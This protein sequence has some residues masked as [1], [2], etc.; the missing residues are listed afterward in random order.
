MVGA[1]ARGD[2]PASEWRKLVA[3]VPAESRWWA[4]RVGEHFPAKSDA[5]HHLPLSADVLQELL[6]QSSGHKALSHQSPRR[7]ETN[8]YSPMQPTTAFI[9]AIIIITTMA[10][11]ITTGIIIMTMAGRMMAKTITRASIVCMSIATPPARA[12]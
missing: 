4:D 6:A 8:K 10:I 2:M 9:L 1:R 7:T 3:L 11:M 12:S 5:V